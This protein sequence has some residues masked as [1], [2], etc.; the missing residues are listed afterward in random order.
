MVTKESKNGREIFLAID[1]NSIVHRAFH[2]YPPTLETSKGI[3]VNAVFGFTSMFLRVLEIFNPKY[4]VCT[5]DTAK[6]TFRHA[7][8]ADYK[9]TRKPTDQS[10]IAQF[11]I[12]EEVVK[13]FNVPILKKEGYEADDILGTLAEF[14]K[15]GRWSNSNVHLC[16]VSGDTDLLQLVDG[17]VSVILPQGNFRNLKEFM[18]NDV[19]EKMGVYPEQV[20][21]YK[22]IVGDPSDNI[23][24][25]KGI[26]CKTAVELLKNHG[27]LDGIYANIA[28]LSTRIQNLLTEGAEQAGFSRELAE[29]FKEVD[30]QITLESC[31][32]RDFNTSEVTE[33]FVELEFRSL[34]KKIPESIDSKSERKNSKS[35]QI[36]LF[37]TNEVGDNGIPFDKEALKEALREPKE[38]SV[39]YFSEERTFLCRTVDKEGKVFETCAPV[40]DGEAVSR[41]LTTLKNCET[42]FYDFEDFVADTE[43]LLAIEGVHD[44]KLLAHIESSG[45]RDYSFSNLCFEYLLRHVPDKLDLN[46]FS[47]YFDYLNEIFEKISQKLSE[48]NIDEEI[49]GKKINF[50]EFSSKTENSLALVLAEMEK[51]G[52]LIETNRLD[53]LYKEL[54]TEINDLVK[55]IYELVG[56]EFNINSSKQLS[57]LLFNELGLPPISKTKTSL[58]TKEEVLKKLE[59]S[60][61]VISKILDY[62]QKSKLMNNYLQVYKVSVEEGSEP[63]I[64]TDFKQTGTSSGRLSSVNP[65]MQNLPAGS[66][67]AERLR[68]IFVP[69]EGFVFV[70]ADYSQIDLRVMAHLSE[71]ENLIKDFEDMKDIHLTTSAR[72]LKKPESEISSKERRIGKTIN[73]GII[74]GLT[75]FGLSER[76]KIS[77]SEADAYIKEYFEN[78]KGVAEYINFMT[79]EVQ[80]TRYVET[81]LGRRRYVPGVN[82]RNTRVQR[83]AIREAINMPVQGGS[84]DIMKL[85][86]VE[87]GDL[88]SEKFEK[89]AFMLLQIHDEIIFEVAE[90]QVKDFEEE[91][92]KV[93]KNVVN[94]KV[95]LDL[96]ISNGK[97][98]AELN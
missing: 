72:I 63:V 9:A 73:F 50:L 1:A 52:I 55:D 27:N 28:S 86:M 20:V 23:P 39:I 94:L 85:A 70:S 42:V 16:I 74:Y 93:M 98:M 36:G 37:G 90:D 75:S 26:G 41:A 34:I 48:R 68:E 4:I 46:D 14:V 78:Y 15:S 30:L 89:K 53:I 35:E 82:S 80:N 11:P 59:G 87:L 84:A 97:N 60:H 7:K 5:F 12:V 64:H 77:V 18:R 25:V 69:R 65:N 71:D 54:D 38:I 21:D 91:I 88:I 13:S 10:L 24:G 19:F 31:L 58:S 79:K 3:Q 51:R 62:R 66:D 92:A 45:L 81:I 44:I 96:N 32:Q 67:M 61:P 6:P 57:D 43:H 8:Y 33:K 29:I 95:P 17:N 47:K 49:V 22:A 56:H 76:L 40:E 2:S 83:A